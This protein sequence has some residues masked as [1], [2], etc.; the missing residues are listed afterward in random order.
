MDG[1]M[2]SSVNMIA[3]KDCDAAVVLVPAVADSVSV[4]GPGPGADIKS[5]AGRACAIFADD[6]ALAAF[7]VDAL[8]PACRI[9]SAQAGR[10]QGRRVAADVAA[11][12]A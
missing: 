3:V 12:L 4:F 1:G 11:F 6:E 9:P 8:D 10:A 2:G 7:G 5:F